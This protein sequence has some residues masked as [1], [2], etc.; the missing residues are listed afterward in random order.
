[1]PKHWKGLEHHLSEPNLKTTFFVFNQAKDI[2]LTLSNNLRIK[3]TTLLKSMLLRSFHKT[4]T[5]KNFTK[6]SLEYFHHISKTRNHFQVKPKPLEANSAIYNFYVYTESKFKTE[7]GENCEYF[8][9]LPHRKS[10]ADVRRTKT[11]KS[12]QKS[13]T[14]FGNSGADFELHSSSKI[15]LT[16]RF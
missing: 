16:M 10:V 4:Q 3:V 2:Y 5:H 12:A 15:S 1:M 13:G 6:T 8:P 7:K 11:G 9:N 14:D